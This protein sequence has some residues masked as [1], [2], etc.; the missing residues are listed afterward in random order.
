LNGS[1]LVKDPFKIPLEDKAELLLAINREA[2]KVPGIKFATA[3]YQAIAE[4]GEFESC[5]HPVAP[6]Q[7][8]WEYV[9]RASHR[10][11]RPRLVVDRRPLHE[12]LSVSSAYASRRPAATVARACSSTVAAALRHPASASRGN[13]SACARSA[14]V[15][16]GSR[17]SVGHVARGLPA[18]AGGYDFVVHKIEVEVELLRARAAREQRRDERHDPLL[19]IDD[20]PG[21]ALLA[22]LEGEIAEHHLTRC[23]DL[24]PEQEGTDGIT[25]PDAIEELADVG[26]IPLEPAL[27]ARHADPPRTCIHEELLDAKYARLGPRLRRSQNGYHAMILPRR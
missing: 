3:S 5:D 24:R 19:T 16:G 27:K 26:P 10:G 20:E 2:M 1:A 21:T 7:A 12:V 15:R 22:D 17:V 25:S 6:R 23:P 9:E 8:G 13:R 18:S 14:A 11:R 4:R